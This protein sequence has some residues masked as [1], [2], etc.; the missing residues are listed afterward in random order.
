MQRV[1]IRGTYTVFSDDTVILY[2]GNAKG[3]LGMMI[4]YDMKLLDNWLRMNMLTLN[5][6]KK[7]QYMIYKQKNKPAIQI[8]IS[9]S[10]E[11]LTRTNVVAYLGM[12]MLNYHVKS[13]KQYTLHM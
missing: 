7:T 8:N 11:S 13:Q 10:G 2:S 1:G 4:S 3:E 6:K 9:M 12:I 5:V